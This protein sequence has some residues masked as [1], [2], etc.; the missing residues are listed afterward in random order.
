MKV[1]GFSIKENV[2]SSGKSYQ[3]IY[4][5]TDDKD[6]PE[7]LLGF[8]NKKSIKCVPLKEKKEN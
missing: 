6:N 1:V 7:K 2:S 4:V 3:A 5:I 8:L